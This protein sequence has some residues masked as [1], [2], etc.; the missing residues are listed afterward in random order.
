MVDRPHPAYVLYNA[1]LLDFAAPASAARVLGQARTVAFAA[2]ADDGLREVAEV[3][4]PIGLLP[5]IDAT[6]VNV[7]G[8]AQHAVAGGRL[9]GSAQPGWRALR[10]LAELLGARGFDFTDLDGL[11]AGLVLAAP[12]AAADRIVVSAAEDAAGSTGCERIATLSIYRS[13]AVV[14]R[15]SALQATPLGASAAL[16]V[17]AAQAARLGLVDGGRAR[18]AAGD[19]VVELPVQLDA[20]VPDGAVRVDA[21]FQATAMLPAH[22]RLTITGV[23]A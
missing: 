20:S 21:G 12:A 7:D 1:E 17:S 22:G 5:E 10:A 19:A 3:I 23:P 6:L 13:D 18:V 8:L 14:R 16:R 15:A 9:P 2:F 4:L 11:R